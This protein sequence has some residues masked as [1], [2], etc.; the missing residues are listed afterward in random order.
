MDF[1]LLEHTHTHPKQ[2]HI[3]GGGG[4]TVVAKQQQIHHSQNCD[5][6]GAMRERQRERVT[7]KM[8]ISV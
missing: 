2:L 8:A 4:L 5:C 1:H 6:M 3:G 7:H